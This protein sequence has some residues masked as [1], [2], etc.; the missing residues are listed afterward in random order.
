[1]TITSAGNVGIGTTSPATT[2]QLDAAGGATIRLQRTSASANRFD[3]GTDG[4]NMEFNVRD[5]GNFTFGGTISYVRLL[6]GTGGIQFNGD[7]AAANALDDYEEGTWTMGISFGGAST[8]IT[9][10]VNTGTYTKIG[11]QVTVTGLMN[12]TNKGTATG[13]AQLTGLP[14]S[15]P[16]AIEN[17]S[18]ASLWLNSVTFLGQFE[19][20]GSIN[21]TQVNLFQNN[22]GTVTDLT[23]SNF[24]NN[25]QV[26]ISLTY[27]L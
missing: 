2:L 15:I 20:F 12:L 7:T 14:F 9:Y 22:L 23:D 10:Q 26:M 5:T 18:T 8:G 19:A 16:N 21:S 6:S 24:A 27:F 3:V 1:M 17:Y 13:I 4:T 11:R 25:S